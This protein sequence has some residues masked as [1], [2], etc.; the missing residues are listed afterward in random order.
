MVYREHER[1]FFKE[2]KG[3]IGIAIRTGT[4]IVPAYF[5]GQSQ[6]R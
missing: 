4:D 5:L 2:R 1:I 3:I 6:V